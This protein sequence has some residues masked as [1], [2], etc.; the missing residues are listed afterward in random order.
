MHAQGRKITGTVTGSQD[1]QPIPGATVV[2]MGTTNGTITD[3]NGVYNIEMPTG[4]DSLE[5]RSVGMESKR[6]DVG[7][8]STVNVVLQP[9]LYSLNE[10]VVTALGISR[11][12]KSVGYSM[13]AVGSDELTK[14]K[15]R[16]ALNALEGKVA[17]VNI[18]SAS[19]APG[20]S[21][22]ILIRGVSSLTGSNQPLFI[23]D[24]VP[25]SNSQSGSSS[26]N[27]GTDFGNKINDIN[28][29]DIASISVLKGAS[30]T[31]LY[32][33]RAALP[34]A[35]RKTPNRRSR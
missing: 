32:G 1:Q 13:T 29:N 35:V 14:G 24:G 18:T 23:I 5:F 11:Q 4:K 26:I 3:V 31:A 10:V 12:A 9:E 27:G 28:P 19:G 30:G 20:S 22:R 34:K 8:Q 21:T 6:V 33:S 7:N 15:D 25:V 2:V 16:S 17:G